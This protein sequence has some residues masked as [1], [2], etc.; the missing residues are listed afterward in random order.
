MSLPQPNIP[1]SIL[2]SRDP[3]E[4]TQIWGNLAGKLHVTEPEIA[5]P[6]LIV[7]RGAAPGDSTSHGLIHRPLY[8]DAG[9]LLMPG[10]P[11][12]IFAMASHAYQARSTLST[13][14]ANAQGEAK[15]DGVGDVGSILPGKYLAKL[16][17]SKPYPIFIVNTP[18]HNALLP[19][20]RD[21][22]HDTAVTEAEYIASVARSDKASAVLIHLGYNAPQDSEHKS[23]IA[24]LTMSLPYLRLLCDKAS[25]TKKEVIVFIVNVQDAVSIES[26]REKV[27][28]EGNIA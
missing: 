7:V 15:K 12:C 25:E 5:Q 8:D 9:V 13:D 3:V 28:A 4:Q 6:T 23:S 26:G 24:C 18:E 2:W 19:C 16:A 21:V 14:V 22:N 17:M 10:E 1:C 27:S 11:P 20:V